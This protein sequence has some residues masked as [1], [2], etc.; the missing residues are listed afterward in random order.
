MRC[1]VNVSLRPAG[2]DLY[3]TRA[4]L[5][6][7]NSFNSVEEAAEYEVERQA[8]ILNAGGEVDQE[9]RLYDPDSG[10]TRSMRSKEDAPD[11]RYFPNPDLPPI[12]VGK[13]LLNK[14][15]D[16]MPER[17]EARFARYTD[18][19]G[20]HPQEALVLVNAASLGDY[21]EARLVVRHSPTRTPGMIMSGLQQENARRGRDCMELGFRPVCMAQTVDRR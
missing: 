19:R 10:T 20:L 16:S 18:E 8:E 14:I 6:N 5:K 3:G 15:S 12:L 1:D 7:L 11:Y 21:Y 9:T 4:E 17:P 13:A 2:S